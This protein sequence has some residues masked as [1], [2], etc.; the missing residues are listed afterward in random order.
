MA[1]IKQGIVDQEYCYRLVNIFQILKDF[2][3]IDLTHINTI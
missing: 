1:L 3:S 2:Y